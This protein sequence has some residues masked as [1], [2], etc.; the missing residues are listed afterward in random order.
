LNSTVDIYWTAMHQYCVMLLASASRDWLDYANL[1]VLA[2]TLTSVVVYCWLTHRLRIA[3]ER[4]NDAS[5][6]PVL[7]LNWPDP[8]D[9]RADI[10]SVENIGKGPAF[11]T[12]RKAFGQIPLTGNR[13]L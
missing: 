11:N 5:V 4:Q 12:A 2:A 8:E 7:V 13:F 9:E 6:Y 10:P 3:A 1:I